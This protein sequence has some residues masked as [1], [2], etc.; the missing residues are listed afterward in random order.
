MAHRLRI[1]DL[2][3]QLWQVVGVWLSSDNGDSS[4]H[5]TSWNGSVWWWTCCPGARVGNLTEQ[6]LLGVGR[7]KASIDLIVVVL[8]WAWHLGKAR[9]LSGWAFCMAGHQHCG[10]PGTQDVGLSNM[11]IIQAY[12]T[13][14]G[15]WTNTSVVVG[16]NSVPLIRGRAQV[17][18]PKKE[19]VSFLW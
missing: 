1:S 14:L 11:A 19:A 15:Q 9:S 18:L 6:K 17:K 7:V 10:E 2:E 5:L 8:I 12:P 16:R 13:L 3:S 4:E